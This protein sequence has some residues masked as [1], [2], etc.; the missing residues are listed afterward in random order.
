MSSRAMSVKYIL[1]GNNIKS[2]VDLNH[3]YSMTRIQHFPTFA[4]QQIVHDILLYLLICARSHV[5][6]HWSIRP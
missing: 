4:V 3:L 5:M 6:S 1:I 2:R